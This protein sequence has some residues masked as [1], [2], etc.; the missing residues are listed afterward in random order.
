MEAIGYLRFLGA[1]AAVLALL[2][3]C[4]YLL[5]RFADRIPGLALPG[6]Q[7]RG[8]LSVSEAVTIDP[9]RR[10]LLV[11]RDDVEHLILVSGE[12]AV[13]VETAISPPSA[14]PARSQSQS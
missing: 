3:G 5:R 7:R 6:S 4:A 14:E 12:S 1:L 2:I 11:R 13:V 10:L 8:R 9:R